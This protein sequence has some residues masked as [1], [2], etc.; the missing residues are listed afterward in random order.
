MFIYT[1]QEWK[2]RWYYILKNKTSQKLYLG[3]TKQDIR[4]Y[5]GSGSYW[6]NH[7]KKHGGYTRE[8]I[9]TVWCKFY[10]NKDEAELFLKEFEEQTPDYWRRDVNE[11][12]ANQTRENTSDCVFDTYK[13]D[14]A[15]N[16]SWLDNTYRDPVWRKTV[17]KQKN[18]KAKAKLNDR[19]HL[20]ESGA[21]ENWRRSRQAV[22]ADK[23]KEQQR[24]DKYRESYYN[25]INDP[26]WQE[27]IRKQWRQ[28]VSVAARSQRSK[29]KQSRL[30]DCPVCDR[31]IDCANLQRHINKHDRNKE[32]NPK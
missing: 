26:K 8:N 7:C 4:T 2:P 32:S 15:H 29:S 17:M 10:S 5:L 12:W 19:Q 27:T 1:K 23:E 9:E 25:T 14:E 31:K 3:Q 28:K 18:A 11:S 6:Q 20:E 13:R 16:E 24:I 30:R 22:V 21:I